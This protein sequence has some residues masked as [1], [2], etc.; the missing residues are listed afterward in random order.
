MSKT[1]SITLST[2]REFKDQIIGDSILEDSII[3]INSNLDPEEVFDY[4]KLEDWA[5][6]NGF[7][8]EEEED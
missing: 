2:I 3:F 6:S 1:T 5:Y 4:E 8:K 7:I